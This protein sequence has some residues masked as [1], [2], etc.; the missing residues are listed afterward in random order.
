[1]EIAEVYPSIMPTTK[2]IYSS[3]NFAQ[4]HRQKSFAF[5]YLSSF[6]RQLAN[7]H[8][9]SHEML[10]K[11]VV[12]RTR[13]KRGKSEKKK[14]TKEKRTHI[15]WMKTHRNGSVERRTSNEKAKGVSSAT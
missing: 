14:F 11:I 5:S 15:Q 6:V 8:F 10:D 12:R 13:A 1:M 4:R 7:F 9:H 3:K 2:E